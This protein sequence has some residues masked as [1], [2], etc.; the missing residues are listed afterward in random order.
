MSFVKERY[1]LLTLFLGA[2]S[3]MTMPLLNTE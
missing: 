2:L 1:V 3:S